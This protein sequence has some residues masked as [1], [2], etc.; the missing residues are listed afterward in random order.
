MHDHIRGYR[1]QA[2]VGETGAWVK[3]HG[4]WHRPIHVWLYRGAWRIICWPCMTALQS[5][6]DLHDG[7]WRTQAAA[8]DAAYAHC[9][10][11]RVHAVAVEAVA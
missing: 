2:F 10:M 7:G 5:G 4:D 8:M 9:W 3:R 1:L 11:C 6:D